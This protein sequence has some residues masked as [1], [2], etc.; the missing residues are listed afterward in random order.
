MRKYRVKS[1]NKLKHAK[2]SVVKA[3]WLVPLLLLGFAFLSLQ[4]L[5]GVYAWL[6]TKST[7]DNIVNLPA[8][9]ASIWEGN[10][11]NDADGVWEESPVTW[12][13]TQE[14]YVKFQNEGSSAVLLR[15]SYAETWTRKM[16]GSPLEYLSSVV[17]NFPVAKLQYGS[18]G[19]DKTGFWTD[20]GDGWYYY[21]KIL[22]PGESTDWILEGVEFIAPTPDGYEEASYAL[23]F[24][25]ESIQYSMNEANENDKVASTIFGK[26]FQLTDANLGLLTWTP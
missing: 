16:E 7:V 21:N 23:D 9:E 22:M 17:N 1:R 14:K 12:G 15:A 2:K 4:N 10:T 18:S 20:G 13:Y 8:L 26:N 24:R 11:E 6:S 25:L 19:F 5:S 3:V